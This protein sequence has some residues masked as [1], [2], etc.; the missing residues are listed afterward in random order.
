MASISEPEREENNGKHAMEQQPEKS[1]G[2]QIVRILDRL[3]PLLVF[4][5]FITERV[6]ETKA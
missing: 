1:Y 4:R 3:T 5:Y 2:G 6:Q